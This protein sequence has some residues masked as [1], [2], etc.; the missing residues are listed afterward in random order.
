VEHPQAGHRAKNDGR[1]AEATNTVHN[2][3]DSEDVA[4]TKDQDA[5][6]WFNRRREERVL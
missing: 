2:I 1:S 5:L 6:G 4:L 3:D